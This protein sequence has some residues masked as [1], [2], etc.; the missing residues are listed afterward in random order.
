M[1]FVYLL[2]SHLLS[3]YLSL[4]IHI[5]IYICVY[6]YIHMYI[7]YHIINMFI[8]C[9]SICS[10]LLISYV[11]YI[12]HTH[13]LLFLN[14]YKC[15]TCISL[16][17]SISVYLSLYVYIYIYIWERERERERERDIKHYIRELLAVGRPASSRALSL[18]EH[19][20]GRIKPGRNKRAALSLQNQTYYIF[21]VLIRP[22]WYASD[23]QQLGLLKA[24]LY[25]IL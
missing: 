5:Y 4:S 14:E 18:G 20:P 12:C 3:I 9:I 11:L 25:I 13:P 17:L 1:L 10:Y 15:N 6:V 24:G 23:V 8:L 7:K 22:R 2:L 16:S 19:K 21:V